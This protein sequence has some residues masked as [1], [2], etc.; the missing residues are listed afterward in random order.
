MWN[1]GKII[2][3]ICVPVLV[4]SL[5]GCKKGEKEILDE[6]IKLA[7][8]AELSMSLADLKK[9]LSSAKDDFERSD[10]HSR[11][12][13]M[14]ADKGD[15]GSAI[16]SAN[17]SVKFYPGSAKAHYLLGKS[18]LTA[19]RYAESE[20]EL[21]TA[22]G[23]DDKFQPAHFELGNLYYKMRKYDPAIR[24]YQLAIQYKDTD[25]QAH[26]NL[27]AVYQQKGRNEDAEKEFLKTKEL[28]PQ[29]AGVYKNLGI[30]YETRLKKKAE[31]KAAYNEYLKRNPNASDRAAVKIWIANLGN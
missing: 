4:L 21:M 26:N 1:L 18:Y 19:G 23:I 8:K 6:D 3:C 28:H 9:K 7:G 13:E 22:V 12:S 15:V 2:L 17:D 16:R 25:Y 11:I 24:E 29:F 27:G 30:L 5:A 10:L 31:A 20:N 14:E